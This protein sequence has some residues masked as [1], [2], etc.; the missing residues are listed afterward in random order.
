MQGVMTWE[1][2]VE[3]LRERPSRG[4]YAI[5]R[6]HIEHPRDAGL[7]FSAGLP[8]G[9]RATYLGR[10]G[11]GDGAVLMVR[12]F[13]DRYH[14]HLRVPVARAIEHQLQDTPGAS[15]LALAALGG[16]I[17][18]AVGR[19]GE[20][21][22]AGALVGGVVGMGAVAVSTAETKPSTSA[23]ALNTLELATR[24]MQAAGT[25]GAG[26]QKPT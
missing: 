20:A 14:A 19:S 25:M 23:A 2:M 16:V 5:A 1:Q 10:T 6:H 18:L 8:I 7:R 9:Q 3:K 15:L 11:G 26:G 12:E 22:L 21:A 24:A 4:G 17:G 13:G